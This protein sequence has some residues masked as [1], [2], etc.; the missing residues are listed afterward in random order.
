[1]QDLKKYGMS[2]EQLE[3]L[4]KPEVNQLS[5]PF[6]WTPELYSFG[7]CIRT[8]N[9]YPGFLPLFIYSDH[10]AG[11][12][13]NL[14]PHELNNNSN[15][16]LTWH[17]EKSKRYANL[18]DRKIL[19][20]PHPWIGYRRKKGINKSENTSGTIV[21]FT[22][23]VPG[24][25][26]EGHSTEDY[27]ER[28][29]NLPKEFHPIVLCLHMHDIN[30]G[31]HKVLRKYGFPIVTAGNTVSYNFVDRFYELI[32]TFSYGTSQ[33]WGSQVAYCIELGIPYFFFGNRPK[34][35]NI[36]HK[37]MPIGEVVQ[38]QDEFHERYYKNAVK[39]FSYPQTEVTLDQKAFVT[40][41]L[42]LDSDL[43]QS[44]L[45]RIL[46]TEFF[47]HWRDWLMIPKPIAVALLSKI[48]LLDT[49]KK[50][51]KLFKY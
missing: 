28:L 15:V 38:Y 12:H 48:K 40:K 49:T 36:K 43:D 2:N 8:L 20:V 51:I 29:R 42:G 41:I 1:M 21:F 7:K 34:L 47:R 23:H 31:H 27:F 18:K 50:V 11:L 16:H 10:G 3:A 33:E 14:Y 4:C 25:R 24:I 30:A 5:F 6:S 26:W 45:S 22:H 35:I 39:L 9:A 37:E 32:K 46:W 13:S 44:Y 17:P 19:R